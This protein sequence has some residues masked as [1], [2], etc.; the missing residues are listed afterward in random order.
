[1]KYIRI[2]I[3][4]LKLRTLLFVAFKYLFLKKGQQSINILSLITM[5][6]M[7][8]GAAA[9]IVVLSVFNGFEDIAVSLYESFQPN[10][11]I[12][13][14]KNK[15]FSYSDS[16]F[17][18]L[19]KVEGIVSV[20]KVYET[21]AYFKY[22]DKESVGLLKGVDVNYF[23]TN[24]VAKYM[25]HGDSLLED[26]SNSYSLIGVALNDKLNINYQNKFESLSVY[27]P[28]T[29]SGVGIGLN[30][31]FE[32]NYLTPRSVFSVYQEFDDK[33][34]IAPLSFVQYISNKE[35][36]HVTGLEI[37]TMNDVNTDLI[38][39][40][41]KDFLPS[42]LEVVDRLESNETLY[43]ITKIEKLITFL[44]M[45][46]ILAILSLN[47]VG[48]L[49]M[50]VIE[51][52]NDL[53]VLRNIGFS[54][55]DIQKLYVFIGTIQGLVGGIFGLLVGLFICFVQ[56]QF[57]FVKMPGNGTFVIQDYPIDVKISDVLMI[58][59]LLILIS[60]VVSMF[61]AL[62]AKENIKNLEK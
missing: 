24:S 9:L 47:F 61:P 17:I 32:V 43:R 16:F 3:Y 13:P 30:S 51:K 25:L 58:L 33:Y 14:K 19:N 11:K 28:K 36:N 5:F 6:A 59:F 48:S 38:K 27:F 40:R 4:N 7:G 41:I 23:K 26:E 1:M 49:S 37:K 15:D 52:M 60:F 22:M 55:F 35:D 56:K 21:K 10:L 53:I 50:H 42:S 44:I 20:S 54:S 62:K 2:L 34:V 46:F 18:K 57:G 31:T 45:S 29:N 39:D 8:I 12:V